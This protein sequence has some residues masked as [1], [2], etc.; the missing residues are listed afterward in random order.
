MG[1]AE[2][3]ARPLL[4]LA[5]RLTVSCLCSTRKKPADAWVTFPIFDWFS[6]RSTPLAV[7][8][9]VFASCFSRCFLVL[10][11]DRTL[12]PRLGGKPRMTVTVILPEDHVLIR[13]PTSFCRITYFRCYRCRCVSALHLNTLNKQRTMI[14]VRDFRAGRHDRMHPRDVSKQV[15]VP[16]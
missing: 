9:H 16:T 3:T 7:A 11:Q 13:R 2:L 14:L 12:V 6:F 8:G 5:C 1:L 10:V 15:R 4:F